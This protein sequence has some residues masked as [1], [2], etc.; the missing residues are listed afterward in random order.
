MR[1]DLTP[2]I[3]MG[4]FVLSMLLI[5]N[6][7]VLHRRA[8]HDGSRGLPLVPLR[9]RRLGWALVTAAAVVVLSGTV[10]TG[11]GPHG[12]DADV[13]RLSFEIT[14]VVRIHSGAMW[15]F[16]LLSVWTLFELR[17]TGAP[18]IV[19]RWSKILVGV[20]V[21]QGAIGYIQYFTGVPP[22]VVML[23]VFGS[24]L[25]WIAVLEL[26]LSFTAHPTEVPAPERELAA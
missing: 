16:L 14:E 6:A 8:G 12:G 1:T 15:V 9:I 19:D 26:D 25:V 10:V 24:T 4:H 22:G 17:R 13:E 2:P 18:A 7:V 11:T 20:I 23:H 5:W 3:V 21:L